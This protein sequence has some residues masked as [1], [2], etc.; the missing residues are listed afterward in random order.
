MAAING[1]MRL[2]Q[3]L[4]QRLLLLLPLLSASS[5]RRR[6]RQWRWR[7]KE[8]QDLGCRRRQDQRLLLL[9]LKLLQPLL[10]RHLRRL[11]GRRR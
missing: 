5:G 9:P 7:W 1:D 2:L 10:L 11:K 8:R 3:L 4:L 6:W